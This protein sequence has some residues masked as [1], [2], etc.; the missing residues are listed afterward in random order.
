MQDGGPSPAEYSRAEESAG[1]AARLRSLGDAAVG[2]ASPAGGRMPRAATGGVRRP[3]DDGAGRSLARG[4]AAA[5]TARGGGWADW[6]PARAPQAVAGSRRP[7]EPPSRDSGPAAAPWAFCPLTS[8]FSRPPSS[9]AAAI[10]RRR[11]RGAHGWVS[12]DS[13][14]PCGGVA[15]LGRT[16]ERALEE[17]T[18]SPPLQ[19]GSP[20]PPRSSL[21]VF[22]SLSP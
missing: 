12:P 2:S 1:M 9:G 8:L 11:P 14:G 13:E 16:W 17:M 5:P 10:R 18:V 22:Q 3:E 6:A 4:G 21:C 7:G 15:G 20:P 19:W